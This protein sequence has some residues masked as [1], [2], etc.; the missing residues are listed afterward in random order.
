MMFENISRAQFGLKIDVLSF[1][2][3]GR[4]NL[5]NF[6]LSNSQKYLI[7]LDTSQKKFN[8]LLRLSNPEE[9]FIKLKLRTCILLELLVYLPQITLTASLKG[10]GAIYTEVVEL[11]VASQ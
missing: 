1:Q 6:W 8:F 2:P 4:P 9:N 3:P 5:P 7:T 10:E 11:M